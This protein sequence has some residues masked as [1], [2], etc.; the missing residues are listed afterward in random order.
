MPW[1]YTVGTAPSRSTGNFHGLGEN[2][3]T[4]IFID[5]D[6]IGDERLLV[7]EPA[8]VVPDLLKYRALNE[9]HYESGA[10]F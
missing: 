2:P 10:I 3:R 5:G 8:E 9:P 4:A 1:N 6:I 7:P